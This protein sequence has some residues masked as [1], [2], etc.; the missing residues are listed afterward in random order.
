MSGKSEGVKTTFAVPE[1][2]GQVDGA[3]IVSHLESKCGYH[4]KLNRIV[5]PVADKVLRV[6]GLLQAGMFT[7][8][9]GDASR[10]RI[11]SRR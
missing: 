7:L 5:A 2:V 4:G 8:P 3:A 1:I 11:V 9:G 6:G 10:L